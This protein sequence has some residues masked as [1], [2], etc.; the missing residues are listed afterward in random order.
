MMK[1]QRPFLIP[2]TNGEGRSKKR[3]RML[4]WSVLGDVQRWAAAIYVSAKGQGAKG[5]VK[6]WQQRQE[7]MG[8]CFPI[9]FPRLCRLQRFMLVCYTQY[10]I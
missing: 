10:F 5:E 7:G 1:H 4:V 8:L 9:A 3:Q 2:V 6:G